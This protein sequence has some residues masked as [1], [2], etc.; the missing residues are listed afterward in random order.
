MSRLEQLFQQ[1]L[2]ER[3]YINNVTASTREWYECAWKA[4][5]AALKAAPER[6]YT[7]T[8]ISKTDLQHFVVHLRERG[9]KPVTCNTWLRAMN[10]FCRWLHDQGELPA[11]VKLKPQ[12]LEKRIIRTHDDAELKAIVT[13]RPKT[14]TVGH[15]RRVSPT[16]RARRVPQ[17]LSTL[18]LLGSYEL[19]KSALDSRAFR[20][21]RR[22]ARRRYR[23]VRPSRIGGPSAGQRWLR[24]QETCVRYS[25]TRP[26]CGRI[27]R[28][29]RRGE[30]GRGAASVR[31][32]LFRRTWRVG[33]DN[34]HSVNRVTGAS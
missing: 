23:P 16:L 18:R 2:R 24:D 17:L 15:D 6:D 22:S 11:P 9:V 31:R 21:C 34:G 7:A 20:R 28:A 25:L 13:Y 32:R 29:V 26:S 30:W 1:F 27:I 8:L 12:R 14:F 33:S 5:T 10:A 3:T 19:M 4:F